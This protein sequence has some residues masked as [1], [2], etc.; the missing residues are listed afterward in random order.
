MTRRQAVCL[1]AALITLA[2]C[3]DQQT[4]GDS[5]AD[6][7]ATIAGKP[8]TKEQAD[9]VRKFRA[10]SVAKVSV[11]MATRHLVGFLR[12]TTSSDSIRL[13]DTVV[14]YIAPSSGG[15]KVTFKRDQLADRQNWIVKTGDR[16]FS[17]VP[18]PN[19][20][21][22][23]LR[24]GKHMKCSAIDLAGIFP[25]LAKYPHVGALLEPEVGGS[26]ANVWNLTFVFDE[27]QSP[28][29]IAVVYDNPQ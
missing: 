23:M 21:K 18:P 16:N 19:D 9:S 14:A 12:G 1:T 27:T 3:R 2:A 13:A 6:V 4:M 29:L 28:K 15:G 20:T 7:P 5:M 8:I 17:L 26:C 11:E 22:L 25:D 24:R 10:D